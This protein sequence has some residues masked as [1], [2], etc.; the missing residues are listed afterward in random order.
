MANAS[1]ANPPPSLL[2]TC[3]TRIDFQNLL[4]HHSDDLMAFVGA[5]I[6]VETAVD[7][8][9][10]GVVAAL[11]ASL[12][13][14]RQL[15]LSVMLQ[16]L[17]MLRCCCGASWCCQWCCKGYECHF[18]S[19]IWLSCL[20]KIL[21]LLLGVNWPYQDWKLKI[22]EIKSSKMVLLCKASMILKRTRNAG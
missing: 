2:N 14:W 11:D 4:T 16:W 15:M 1:K 20:Q 17:M 7:A 13:L 22:A 5:V 10:S 8:V 3:W 6:D 12:L 19:N 9:V 21:L 18:D